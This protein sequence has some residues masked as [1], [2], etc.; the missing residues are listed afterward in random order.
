MRQLLYLP[1]IQGRDSRQEQ[2][3]SSESRFDMPDYQH[4][5]NCLRSIENLNMRTT[6]SHAQIL[7]IPGTSPDRISNDEPSISVPQ[8]QLSRHPKRYSYN[9]CGAGHFYDRFEILPQQ[10]ASTKYTPTPTSRHLHNTVIAQSP[11]TIP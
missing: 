11:M 7:A 8:R 10:S 6:F 1:M 5:V 4:P 3:R 2:A 9:S